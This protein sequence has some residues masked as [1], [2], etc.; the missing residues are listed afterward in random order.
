[1]SK[2]LAIKSVLTKAGKPNV[3]VTTAERDHWVPFGMWNAAGNSANFESYIGGNIDADYFAEGEELISG[4]VAQADNMILR[5]FSA[6]KNPRVLAEMD[7]IESAKKAEVLNE[8]ALLFR[9]RRVEALAKKAAAD[10]AAAKAAADA[11]AKAGAKSGK[12]GK[13]VEVED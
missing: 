1:M 7:A 13:H 2:I 5:T 12:A 11:A 6:S 9:R 8:A 3:L 4:D 10:A